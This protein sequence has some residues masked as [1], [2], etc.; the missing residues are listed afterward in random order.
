MIK[1]IIKNGAIF[2]I[3]GAIYFFIEWAWKGH[4]SHWSM[5]VLGGAMGLLVGGLNEFIPWEMS[6]LAQSLCGMILVTLAE[7]LSGLVLNVWLNLNVWDYSQSFCPFFYNQCC[8]PFCVAWFALSGVCILLDDFIRYK[9]F[10]EEYPHYN[11]SL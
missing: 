3:F 2:L 1:Q 8:V 5:F 11:F 6:F 10:G 7:G 4:I 9:F